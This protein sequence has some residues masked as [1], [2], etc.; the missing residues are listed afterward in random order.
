MFHGGTQPSVSVFGRTGHDGFLTPILIR[1]SP[2][3]FTDSGYAD[4]HSAG[5]KIPLT[6]FKNT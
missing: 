2:Q 6:L 4:T 3:Y 5:F 1:N